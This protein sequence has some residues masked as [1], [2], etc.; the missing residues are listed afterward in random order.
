MFLSIILCLVKCFVVNRERPEED[1]ENGL[2]EPY[3][4]LPLIFKGHFG[5]SK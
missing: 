4:K 2:I 3:D 1:S 5:S